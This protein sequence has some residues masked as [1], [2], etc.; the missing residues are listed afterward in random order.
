VALRDAGRRARGATLYVT[1]EPC[2]HQGRTP[3]C[4]DAVRAAGIARVVLGCSDPNPRVKGNGAGHLRRAGI[5]V[6]AGVLQAE[7]LEQIRFFT[8]HVRTGRPWVTLKLAASLDGRIATANGDSRW[9]T[10]EKARALVHEW[11]DTHDAI[12]VGSETVRRDDP[13]LTCRRKGGRDPLRVVLDGRLRLPLTARVAQS[14]TIVFTRRGAS[15][16]KLRRLRAQGVEVVEL[17][18]RAGELAWRDVQTELGG[19]GV[20]SVLVEGGGLVAASVLRS[21]DV[22]RVSLFYGPKL[23]GGDG[24]PMIGALAVEKMAAALPLEILAVRQLDGDL[25]VEAQR[26]S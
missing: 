15:T 13:A 12:L 4:T 17:R 6:V 23:V 24:R 1:L 3:P 7:C 19:R 5:A 20:C 25:L 2:A 11:R 18:P 16:A 10:G 14:G 8:K 26:Q 9:I 22:D 21:G